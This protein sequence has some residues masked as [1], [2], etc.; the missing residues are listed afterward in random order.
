MQVMQQSNQA[1]VSHTAGRKLMAVTVKVRMFF[2]SEVAQQYSKNNE[3]PS[4]SKDDNTCI[5]EQNPPKKVQSTP[6][7]VINNAEK[8]KSEIIWALKC[9]RSVI[10]IILVLI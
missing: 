1:L 2:K 8:A 10:L 6:H 5:I 9:K 4:T 3:K 7:L